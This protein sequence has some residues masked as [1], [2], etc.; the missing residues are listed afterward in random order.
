MKP[1]QCPVALAKRES[2]DLE[3]AAG[4]LADD[5]EGFEHLKRMSVDHRG[6]GSVLPLGEAVYQ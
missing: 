3:A 4:Q 5:A 6:A 1:Q 2:L